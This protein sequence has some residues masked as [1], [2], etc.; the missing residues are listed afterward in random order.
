VEFLAWNKGLILRKGIKRIEETPCIY[1]GVNGVKTN[2]FVWGWVA[3]EY[4]PKG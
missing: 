4:L 2:L 1:G 3:I